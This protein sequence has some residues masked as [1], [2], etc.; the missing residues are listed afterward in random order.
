M[1]MFFEWPELIDSV[2]FIDINDNNREQWKLEFKECVS[3]LLKSGANIFVPNKDEQHGQCF[4]CIDTLIKSI[5]QRTDTSEFHSCISQT[6]TGTS[7]NL[8]TQSS[9]KDS[10]ASLTSIG[11][12]KKNQNSAKIKRHIDI[13]FIIYF[14]DKI[15]KLDTICD[16]LKRSRQ[17]STLSFKRTYLHK[18]YQSTQS[19]SMYSVLPIVIVP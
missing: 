7:A 1:Q 13:K 15:I 19:L 8:I 9:N 12:A 10:A 3:F 4:N 5:L 2:C 6:L 16:G 11:S 14:L 17:A 18:C